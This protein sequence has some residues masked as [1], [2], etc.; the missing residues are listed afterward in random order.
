[1]LIADD[2]QGQK[3]IANSPYLFNFIV[4]SLNA[5]GDYSH[6]NA[7]VTSFQEQQIGKGKG[8][9]STITQLSLQLREEDANYSHTSLV[10]KV[11]CD[12]FTRRQTNE[13]SYSEDQKE[14]DP[15]NQQM[16]ADIH[17]VE[18]RFYEFI[19]N[20]NVG[21]KIPRF[22]NGVK[23]D[24]DNCKQGIIVM[25]DLSE[26]STTLPIYNSLNIQ[27]VKSIVDEI[28][29]LQCVSFECSELSRD[30]PLENNVVNAISNYSLKCIDA[31]ASR[32]LPW[33][34]E[35]SLQ[36]MKHIASVETI[37]ELLQWTSTIGFRPVL[38]HG[39]LWPNNIL[40]KRGSDNDNHQLSAIVDFQAVHAGIFTAD[41]AAL[42]SVSVNGEQRREMEKDVLHYYSQQMLSRLSDKTYNFG[43]DM[44]HRNYRRSLKYAL[45]QV[46]MTVITN[47]HEDRRKE[48]EEEGVITRRLRL[49]IEDIEES[50]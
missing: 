6:R 47:P 5:A 27:Q 43:I 4:D 42:L 19:A 15:Q 46:V 24:I 3:F 44:V 9:A 17:A 36:K 2:L 30:F 20:K 40:W 45:L 25:E 14:I 13:D 31:L 7:V 29:K 22:I 35:E 28:V 34:C 26:T 49:L 39:D 38:V 33:I 37:K 18:L 10:V 50:L 11:P 1:M 8:L 16:I 21:I 32:Q 12:A 23:C 41:L 48:N